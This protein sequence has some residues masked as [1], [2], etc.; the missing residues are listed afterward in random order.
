MNK[1]AKASKQNRSPLMWATAY[2]ETKTTT[3]H[4]LVLTSFSYTAC[5]DAF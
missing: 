1:I 3:K 2:T 5:Q 4:T